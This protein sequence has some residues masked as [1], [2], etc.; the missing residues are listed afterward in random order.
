MER[1]LKFWNVDTGATV[2]YV[3]DMPIT[4][5]ASYG[6][7]WV[8]CASYINSDLLKKMYE[9]YGANAMHFVLLG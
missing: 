1:F 4:T 8:D 3:K 2:I 5:V 7:V 9:V 6:T